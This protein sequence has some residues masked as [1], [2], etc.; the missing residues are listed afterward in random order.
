MTVGALSAAGVGDVEAVAAFA[1][2]FL[3]AAGFGAF[4]VAAGVFFVVAFV[5]VVV[6]TFAVVVAAAVVV[7][8]TLPPLATATPTSAVPKGVTL[9]PPVPISAVALVT[10]FL[11]ASGV[12]DT[13]SSAAAA[14]AAFVFDLDERVLTGGEAVAAVAFLFGGIARVRRVSSC[15]SLTCVGWNGS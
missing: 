3:G 15:A 8:V 2:A 1:F 6:A 12:L 5:V 13:T 7:L 11:G 14:S 4:F 9:K 10:L